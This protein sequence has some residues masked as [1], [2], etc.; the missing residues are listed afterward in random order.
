MGRSD[1]ME[2]NE[3]IAIVL[4][5]FG[6][7][8]SA[9][10]LAV[11]FATREEVH[12]W[13][14]RILEVRTRISQ[15]ER[16]AGTIWHTG[17]AIFESPDLFHQDRNS[18]GRHERTKRRDKKGQERSWAN[19]WIEIAKRVVRE[20]KFALLPGKF[21]TGVVLRGGASQAVV[22]ETGADFSEYYNIAIHPL[23]MSIVLQAALYFAT[24]M[25]EREEL[26]GE[27]IEESPEAVLDLIDEGFRIPGALDKDREIWALSEFALARLL[28]KRDP[29]IRQRAILLTGRMGRNKGESKTRK[30]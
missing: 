30:R 24:N 6:D 7:D 15:G 27:L 9:E 17:L 13:R 23:S 12:V 5:I 28:Q 25:I 21:V 11:H 29:E 2:E 20:Q 1:K 10:K 22:D 14:E 19:P 3:E 18:I 4:P 8:E 16:L 26:L